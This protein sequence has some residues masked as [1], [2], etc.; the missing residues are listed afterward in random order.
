[1]K[2]KSLSLENYRNIKSLSLTFDE[3]LN[4]IYGDNA[5]GKTNLIEAISLFSGEKSFRCV[6][7]R[8]LV[9]L[10]EQKAKLQMIYETKVREN[11][12]Q[13][14]INGTRNTTLNGLP[15]KVSE[16]LTVKF[17]T[18]VF[19]PTH[20][21]LIKDGPEK[22]RAFLDNCICQISPNYTN[23]LTKYD[24]ALFQ[25][26]SLLKS[27]ALKIMTENQVRM[28]FDVWNAS[29]ASSGSMIYK[30]RLRYLNELNKYASE[31]YSL[32][33]SNREEMQTY[34]L[35]TIF[36]T[37]ETDVY[38]IKE[39]YETALRENLEDD[40]RVGYTQLGIN[41]DDFGV[42]INSIS[43]K[44]FASQG[45]QRSAVLAL[46]F[47][48]CQI[49]ENALDESPVILL[50]DVMSEL[51]KTRQDYILNR[52]KGMQVFLTCCDKDDI[53]GLSGGKLFYI[54]NGEIENKE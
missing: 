5:Q 40:L 48:Q 50:D 36:D 47:S 35:S 30:M 13:I 37:D 10:D 18:V 22:R 25:R 3:K 11:N 52:V 20:L 45:Q 41:R 19:S 8:Q 34:Y 44:N 1:M 32:I 17:H 12:M 39:I 28:A 46:K 16:D 15:F 24:R 21:S 31:I 53:K 2:V 26:N 7:D 4:I 29:L 54:K 23:L 33:T 38:K 6:R 27:P 43:A 42:K 14:E 51:D 49:L 9:K